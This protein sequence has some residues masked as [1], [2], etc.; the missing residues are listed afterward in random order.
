MLRQT[1]AIEDELFKH[2]FFSIGECL[3]NFPSFQEN[4][5]MILKQRRKERRE[6][7]N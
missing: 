5:K 1:T 2:H 7:Q 3:W 4:N 6:K